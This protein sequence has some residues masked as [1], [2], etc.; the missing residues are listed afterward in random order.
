MADIIEKA[1]TAYEERDKA[2]GHIQNMKQT[3]KK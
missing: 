2:N 1:N 3:S